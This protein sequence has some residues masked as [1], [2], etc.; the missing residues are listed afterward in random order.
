MNYSRMIQLPMA[1][2]LF[3]VLLM[4]PIRGFAFLGGLFDLRFDNP[5]HKLIGAN[6]D[7]QAGSSALFGD[8]NGDGRS[9]MIISAPEF[10][11]G[12]RSN[13]GAV[14][15]MLSSDTIPDSLRFDE[16]VEGLIRVFGA[17]NDTRLGGVLGCGDIDNDGTDDIICGVPGGSPSGR[18]SAGEM[19][20]VFGSATPA[21]TID[22]ASPPA[23]VTHV[24]GAAVFDQLGS[25]VAVGD[26]NDDTFGDIL[27]GAPLSTSIRQLTGKVFVIDGAASL[28]T[29]IDLASPTVPITQVFGQVTNDFFGAAVFSADA[30]GDGVD[31]IIVGAPES[32][33]MGRSRAGTAYIIPGSP[34]LADTI[35][36][37]NAPGGGIVQI[38]GTESQSAT[39]TAFAFGDFDGNLTGELVVGAPEFGANDMGA[40]YIID[41]VGQWPDTLDLAGANPPTRLEGQEANANVG[42]NI[43]V[44]DFNL[45]TLD[46]LAI[47]APN[48]RASIGRDRSGKVYI[49]FGRT[50]FAPVIYLA[51]LQSG[52]TTFYG[53]FADDHLGSAIAAGRTRPGSYWD[54]FIGGQFVDDGVELDTGAGY[55]FLG[56]DGITPTAVHGYDAASVDDGIRLQ[57]SL[58]E[59]VDAALMRIT[60]RNE[61]GEQ[62]S[63]DGTSIRQTHTSYEFTDRTV[64][65]GITYRYEARIEGDDPQLL[66]SI[67]VAAPGLASARLE[68]SFPNPFTIETTIPFRLPGAGLADL[69]VFDVRGALVR[70]LASGSFP[71]GLTRITWDGRGA[72]GEPLPSGIYFV[73]LQHG[74]TESYRKLLI[75]K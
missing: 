44:G 59:P 4:S 56:G 15:V 55:L 25:H 11:L 41:R 21:D 18:F 53:A 43:A 5:D 67:S 49:V 20:V 64:A 71:S 10:D 33:P 61:A 8:F 13:C 51:A 58:E 29:V 47:G 30:T 12:A 57:W 62:M 16:S 17:A 72:A 48:A 68:A 37:V 40:I 54:L 27:A 1:A 46:D 36:T 70:T 24:L 74:T 65:A 50:G 23:N 7:D 38:F 34:A 14:F 60:R 39:G 52:T 73:R 6:T 66:F 31:D 26:V 63:F 45:D 42:L 32:S 3:L 22:L 9:D 35:D 2:C 69:S 19:F 28:P 75:I